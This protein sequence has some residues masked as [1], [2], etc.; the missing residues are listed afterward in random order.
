MKF[1][2]FRRE[3]SPEIHQSERKFW[4][5]A[6]SLTFA[7]VMAFATSASAD[8]SSE[9]AN[10]PSSGKAIKDQDSE[11]ITDRTTEPSFSAEQRAWEKVL[12]E[13]LGSFYYPRYLKAKEMGSVTAW[14]YVKDDPALPRVLL[15]GDSIS[16]GYTVPVRNDLEG[17][18]NVHRAPANCGPTRSGLEKLDVWTG[19]GK[20]DIIVVNFGIHDRKTP[21]KI[22][23]KNLKK[24]IAKLKRKTKTILWVTSTPV[25]E[26]ANEYIKGSIDRLNDVA[27]P[28]M[29]KKRIQVIDLHAYILPKLD[30][31]QL[32]KNC[33][34]NNEG[35]SY[36]GGL[37]AE[38]ILK[39]LDG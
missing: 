7:A 34:F 18:A 37:V 27:T 24:I 31:Y 4:L 20:W 30:Q 28:L 29:K 21:S 12:A 25:P 5:P 16:R 1:I 39:S 2:R 9:F 33:H 19:K 3:P 13:N 26:G 11:Q 17:K 6:L 22:Y 10:E 23:E 15:I 14:D 32:Q 8:N 35:Y 38:S 36:M